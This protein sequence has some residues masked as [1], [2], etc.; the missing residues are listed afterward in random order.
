MPP[1]ASYA[2]SAV[3]ANSIQ[4][5]KPIQPNMPGLDARTKTPA[6]IPVLRLIIILVYLEKRKAP[7][8][9]GL[10]GYPSAMILA[11]R[12]PVPWAGKPIT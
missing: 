12:L 9:R 2:V 7:I 1:V 5:A 10:L 11:F 8:A 3:K 6:R 4:A